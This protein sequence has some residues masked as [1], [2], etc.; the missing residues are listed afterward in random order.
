MSSKISFAQFPREPSTSKSAPLHKG[1]IEY[2]FRIP[3][4]SAYPQKESIDDNAPRTLKRQERAMGRRRNPDTHKETWL[5]R[6]WCRPEN[7]KILLPVRGAGQ[8]DFKGLLWGQKVLEASTHSILSPKPTPRRK[9]CPRTNEGN[10]DCENVLPMMIL[11]SAG[12][13]H[14]RGRHHV[15]RGNPLEDPKRDSKPYEL[16]IR[17]R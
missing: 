4:R 11:S 7:V 6:P 1:A 9:K 5:N 16:A 10:P 12:Q 8:H 2:T 15:A 14:R 3:K 17:A 13:N